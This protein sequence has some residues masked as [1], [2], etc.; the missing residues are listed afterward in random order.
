MQPIVREDKQKNKCGFFVEP[1]RSGYPLSRF[2]LPL[3]LKGSYFCGFAIGKT[4]IKKVVFLVVGPLRSGPPRTLVVRFFRRF[5]PLMI[6]V[7]FCLVVRWVYPFPPLLVVPPL[8]KTIFFMC[9][10]P[11]G[12]RKKNPPLMAGP[13]R[14][15][16][17]K[18]GKGWAIKEKRTFLTL[19]F[20]FVAI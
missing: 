3:D 7:V 5:F 18:G 15:P 20:Y 1:L 17:L 19:F 16:P 10:F 6:K 8:K 9:V 2:P 11:E 4:H 14:G 13:L 12:S